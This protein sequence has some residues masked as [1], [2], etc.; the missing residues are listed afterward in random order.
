MKNT[1]NPVSNT[2]SG[3]DS[4]IQRAEAIVSA[5]NKIRSTVPEGELLRGI[6]TLGGINEEA[7]TFLK[8]ED[9]TEQIPSLPKLIARQIATIF[10]EKTKEKT[11]PKHI[12]ARK[13]ERMR[14]EQLLGHYNPEETNPVSQKLKELSKSAPII[15]FLPTGGVDV[16]TSTMLLKEIRARLAPRPNSMIEVN[17]VYQRIYRIGENPELVYDENPLYPGLPL[18]PD[19]TCDQL[20]RSWRSIDHK[21]RQFLWLAVSETKEIHVT[22]DKAHDILDK[23]L[24]PNCLKHFKQR[25]QE[26]AIKFQELAEDEILPQLKIRGRKAYY[27]NQNNNPFQTI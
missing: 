2:L 13:A 8:E 19:G 20:N 18:R 21:V 10:Q 9:L 26:T 5:L 7:L 11:E 15:V 1:E 25:Y 14:F 23:A 16:E 12:S 24:Q 6:Q 3:Y 27:P 22:I 4:K 17:G